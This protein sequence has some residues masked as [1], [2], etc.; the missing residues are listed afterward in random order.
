VLEEFIFKEDKGT[1]HPCLANI[2]TF[3]GNST[4]A[5]ILTLPPKLGLFLDNKTFLK[6][7]RKLFK[8]CISHEYLTYES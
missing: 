1:Y 4:R 2:G 8:V 3:E 6:D 5:C 7:G